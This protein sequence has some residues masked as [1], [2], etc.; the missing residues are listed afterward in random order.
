MFR[1]KCKNFELIDKNNYQ[2]TTHPHSVY[3]QILSETGILGLIIFVNIFL[4][5]CFLTFKH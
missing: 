1:I 3:L 2:C 5:I 4:G